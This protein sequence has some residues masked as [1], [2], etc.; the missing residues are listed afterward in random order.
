MRRPFLLHAI[1]THTIDCSY[2]DPTFIDRTVTLT[3]TQTQEVAMD[4]ETETDE[5]WV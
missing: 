4:D 1:P 2:N 5:E 3:A